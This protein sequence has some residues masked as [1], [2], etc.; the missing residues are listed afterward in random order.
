MTAQ[1]IIVLGALVCGLSACG[2][3]GG[4]NISETPAS[5]PEVSRP[6]FSLAS[7]TYYS[8]ENVTIST[9]T[10]GAT[11]YYTT[12]GRTPTTSSRVYNG[13][14]SVTASIDVRAIA[15]VNGNSNNLESTAHYIINSGG[16]SLSELPI[17]LRSGVP[18]PAGKMGGLKVLDWAGFNAAVTYTF[19]DSLQ[20]QISNYPQLQAT[21]V[22][23]TFYLIGYGDHNSPIWAQAAQDGHEIGN[24][25]QHHCLANGNDCG[26][27]WAG[28]NEVEYDE[29]TAHIK[30][31]YG[32]GNVWTTAAPFG[33]TGYDSVASTRFF[34]NRGA[35]QGQVASDDTEDR[36]NL[37]VHDPAAGET[38]STLN[39]FIELAH[40]SN[41]WQIFMIHSL[42]PGQGYHPVDVADV[43][44]SIDRAKSM[45]DVWI[46]SMVNVGAYWLGRQAVANAAS[47]QLLE[48]SPISWTLPDHFPTG[49]FVR[50]TVTGGT[51]EQNGQ[52]LPWNDAG[53]YEV[54]LDPGSLR[55]YQ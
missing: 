5:T 41:K 21:G 32:I 46:D 51:L 48:G 17:P 36:Y 16:A 34:L 47:E 29:C 38:S 12:D 28:S 1:W 9:S 55:I 19:D 33:D 53:F 50:V 23:M 15:T 35:W 54:A 22:R 20:S 3:S 37:P 2:G 31:Q 4:R 52:A 14:L 25:T 7:G 43:T 30:Q 6:T 27:N 40:S 39:S 18:R 44:A 26:G 49:K 10:P 45:G 13:P 8:A 42:K 11:I 24:H